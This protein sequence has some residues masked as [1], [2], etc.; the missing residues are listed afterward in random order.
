MAVTRRAVRAVTTGIT[1]IM[2]PVAPVAWVLVRPR[3]VR[4]SSK[5]CAE[6]CAHFSFEFGLVVLL[7]L[8][9]AELVG[10]GELRR[11]AIRIDESVP[12]VS[13]ATHD[14]D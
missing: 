12:L 7:L 13:Y 9:S 5:L 6:A 14:A 11:R 4:W 2:A 10:V 1:V 3:A 8:L